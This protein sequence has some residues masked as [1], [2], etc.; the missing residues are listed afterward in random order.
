MKNV[1]ILSMVLGTL[2]TPALAQVT[3]TDV[4]VAPGTP[5]MPYTGISD[6]NIYYE[7]LVV[8]EIEEIYS[9]YYNRNIYQVISY[10]EIDESTEYI[11]V[12]PDTYSYNWVYRL[13][14]DYFYQNTID[15]TARAPRA[16]HFATLPYYNSTTISVGNFIQ[17]VH[18][19]HRPK[20]RPRNIFKYTK[21]SKPSFTK[22]TRTMG[23]KMHPSRRDRHKKYVVKHKKPTKKMSRAKR[24]T[25]KTFRQIP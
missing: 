6:G 7:D 16:S 23:R 5:H 9:S 2:V 1:L 13:Y 25:K 17:P 18:K 10:N 12:T 21:H 20:P 4:K 24:R 22:T 3:P 14:T 19:I 11:T 8:I 15:I